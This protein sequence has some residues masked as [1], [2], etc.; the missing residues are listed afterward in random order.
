[1]EVGRCYQCNA[2]IGGQSSKLRD[3]NARDTG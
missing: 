3:D 1:M 2:E